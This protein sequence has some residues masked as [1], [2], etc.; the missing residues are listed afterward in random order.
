MQ[1]AASLTVTGSGG[2]GATL[3][4]DNG[5]TGTI[6]RADLDGQNANQSFVTGG[7]QSLAVWRLMPGTCTGPTP[8]RAR[9]VGPTWT[10]TTPTRAS[11]PATYRATGSG[12]WTPTTSTG[13][14]P[15]RARLVTGANLDGQNANQ[16]FIASASNARGVAV[17]AAHVYWTE[18]RRAVHDQPGRPGR[19]QN[20]NQILITGGRQPPPQSRSTLATSTGPITGTNG[21]DW[22]GPTWTGRTPTRASSPAPPPPAPWRSM[23]ATSTGRTGARARSAGPTWMGRTPSQAFI[24]GASAPFGVAV[25]SG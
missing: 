15:A 23:P 25:G 10:G 16:S 1:P 3:L 12:R 14:T 4:G 20:A 5:G 8:A 18:P 21:R 13:S 19:G 2:A 11:S 6:G 7:L 9:L 24:I 22:F 17:D